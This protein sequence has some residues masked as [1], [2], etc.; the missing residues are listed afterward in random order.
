LI[1]ANVEVRKRGKEEKRKE[2]MRK[3][4]KEEEE[5]A[6]VFPGSS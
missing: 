6:V 5:R 4:G 2:E 3:R 1:E